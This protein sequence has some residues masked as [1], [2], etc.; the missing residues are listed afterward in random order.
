MEEL[1]IKLSELL[2]ITV[3]SAIKLYP[4]LREQFIYYR[5]LGF[6]RSISLLTAFVL[7]FYIAIIWLIEHGRLDSDI[8]KYDRYYY[9][10]EKDE[11]INAKKKVYEFKEKQNELQAIQSRKLKYLAI[12]ILIFVLSTLAR[13]FLSTDLLIIKEFL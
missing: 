5:A 6:I 12:P 2:D 11:E 10:S 8:N 4:V 9:D 13:Y 7:F 3:E 1:A